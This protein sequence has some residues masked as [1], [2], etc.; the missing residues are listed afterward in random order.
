MSF[1]PRLSLDV[2]LLV[3]FSTACHNPTH[4]HP[5]TLTQTHS[6]RHT[7]TYRH[8]QN[9]EETN[10]QRQTFRHLFWHTYSIMSCTH[11]PWWAISSYFRG[12]FLKF[13]HTMTMT[14]LWQVSLFRNDSFRFSFQSCF[15]NPALSPNQKTMPNTSRQD[16]RDG[17][18]VILPHLWK[19]VAKYKNDFLIRREE[20]KRERKLSWG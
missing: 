19:K 16:Y 11:I 4:T 9:N 2:Y 6:H 3:Y 17:Q 8:T 15:R 5:H 1:S 14:S 20:K 18:K 7:E 10:N 13:N 12:I